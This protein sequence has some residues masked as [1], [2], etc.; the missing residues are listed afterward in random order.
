MHF[1]LEQNGA[2]VL[3]TNPWTWSF[4]MLKT[5]PTRNPKQKHKVSSLP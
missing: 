2:S 1:K 4:R 5:G 3:A